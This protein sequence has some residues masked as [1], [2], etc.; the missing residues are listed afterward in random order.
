MGSW[1]SKGV[2]IA[3]FIKVYIC[4]AVGTFFGHGEPLPGH[5]YI[6]Y[7]KPTV[8]R[9]RGDTLPSQKEWYNL[10]ARGAPRSRTDPIVYIIP[11]RRTSCHP[12][13]LFAELEEVNLY[14]LNGLPWAWRYG[15]ILN[16]LM[17]GLRFDVDLV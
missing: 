14:C 9:K 12:A 15:S 13:V 7:P 2:K 3:H 5:W 17:I 4:L 6:L 1:F 10:E 8:T 16:G 11:V